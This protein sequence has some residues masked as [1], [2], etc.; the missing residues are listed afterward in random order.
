MC[1]CVCCQGVTLT[2]LKEAQRSYGPGCKHA[3]E[4]EAAGKTGSAEEQ[5]LGSLTKAVK[6]QE[7]SPAWSQTDE[8]SPSGSSPILPQNPICRLGPILASQV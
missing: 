1:V 7:L 4:D 3:E 5:P 8:V 2:E 6:S